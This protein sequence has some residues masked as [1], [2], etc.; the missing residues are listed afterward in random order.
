MCKCKYH[1]L[2]C[3]FTE[4]ERYNVYST[5]ASASA[6][7]S[8]SPSAPVGKGVTMGSPTIQGNGYVDHMENPVSV[9]VDSANSDQFSQ[10]VPGTSSAHK[11]LHICIYYLYYD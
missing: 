10:A 8:A 1:S 11:I 6:P 5:S 7:L 3:H 4:I 9:P 2:C